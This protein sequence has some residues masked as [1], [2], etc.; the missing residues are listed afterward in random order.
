MITKFMLVNLYSRLQGEF[1]KAGID[2]S[3]I[4]LSKENRSSSLNSNTTSAIIKREV[5]DLCLEDGCN[6]DELQQLR[7]L[8]DALRYQLD[9]KQRVVALMLNEWLPK[10]MDYRNTPRPG[11]NPANT[12]LIISNNQSLLPYLGKESVDYLSYLVRMS[13]NSDDYA[14]KLPINDWK[15]VLQTLE[16]TCT[17]WQL[18]PT[19]HKSEMLYC[20]LLAEVNEQGVPIQLT[21]STDEKTVV[22]REV[23]PVVHAIAR[24]RRASQSPFYKFINM[25]PSMLIDCIGRGNDIDPSN[26]IPLKATDLMMDLLNDVI[27]FNTALKENSDK[28]SQFLSRFHHGHPLYIDMIHVL[29][30]QHTLMMTSGSDLMRRFG[31]FVQCLSEVTMGKKDLVPESFDV[32]I[33]ETRLGHVFRQQQS[34]ETPCTEC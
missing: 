12:G 15:N 9:G 26:I 16:S 4:V 29:R 24:Y 11:M 33:Q 14:A 3:T 23:I 31:M 21:N 8:N 2:L 34:I 5:E 20:R 22:L 30:E 18:D 32:F 25:M 6:Q 17:L 1:A 7:M 28:A 27:S 19:E 13:T 10:R